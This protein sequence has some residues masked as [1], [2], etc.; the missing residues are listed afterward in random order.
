MLV[1]PIKRAWALA[2]LA[3]SMAAGC[4]KT[5]PVPEDAAT[6]ATGSTEP[7]AP[8][9]PP[10]PE[11]VKWNWSAKS[12]DGQVTLTQTSSIARLCKV[13]AARGEQELW[14]ASICMGNRD[15]AHLVSDDGE[16]VLTV[17]PA[18]VVQGS[19]RAAAVLSAYTRDVLKAQLLASDLFADEKVLAIFPDSLQWLAGARK[20]PNPPPAYLD[21]APDQVELTLI[22]GRKAVVSLDGKVLSGGKP[23]PKLTPKAPTRAVKKKPRPKR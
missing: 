18:P 21:G 16:R 8:E 15:L 10:D 6:G 5:R 4:S 2:L 17:E 9:L 23:A 13:R 1:S 20:Q 11:A 7:V 22:D 14:T 12:R 3:A 19:W